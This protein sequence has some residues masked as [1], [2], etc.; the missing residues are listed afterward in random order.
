[1]LNQVQHDIILK[2][3]EIPTTSEPKTFYAEIED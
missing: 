2:Q 3:L 1:M